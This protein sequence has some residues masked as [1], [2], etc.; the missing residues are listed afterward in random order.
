[1]KTEADFFTAIYEQYVSLR[2]LYLSAVSTAAVPS[3]TEVSFLRGERPRS[4]CY[5]RTAA[6]RLLVQPL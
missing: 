6:L 4:R 3:K 5:G 2:R 1:M